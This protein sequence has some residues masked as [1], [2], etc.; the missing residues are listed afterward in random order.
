M[1]AAV[2]PPHL[3]SSSTVE[4]LNYLTRSVNGICFSSKEEQEA[5]KLITTLFSMLENT[6]VSQSQTI[7]FKSEINALKEELEMDNQ[8]IKYCLEHQAIYNKGYIYVGL[9]KEQVINEDFRAAID[10]LRLNHS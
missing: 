5:A 1:N 4:L 7:L 8:R 2:K 6:N 10:N 3:T 9:D